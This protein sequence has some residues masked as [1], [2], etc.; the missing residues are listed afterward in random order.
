ME[1]GGHALRA[2]CIADRPTDVPLSELLRGGGFDIVLLL[3]DLTYSQL[4]PLERI[5]LPKLGVY[6]NHCAGSYFDALG[7]TD[8]HLRTATVHGL[9]FGGFEGCH[10]YKA[11]PRQWS[12]AETE[13]LL[14]GFPRVDVMVCHSPPE[15]VNDDPGDDAHVGLRGLRAY[16]ERHR[17]ALLVHGHTYPTSPRERVGSTEVRYVSGHRI[18]ALPGRAGAVAKGAAAAAIGAE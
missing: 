4:R 18:V 11:R 15:G 3:G 5:D 2:L 12:Q 17:P 6:G 14:A 7:V 16:V 13:A 1:H 9:T 8:L 10:R